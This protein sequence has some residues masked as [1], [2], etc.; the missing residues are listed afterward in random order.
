ML[1]LLASRQPARAA[2]AILAKPSLSASASFLA[3]SSNPVTSKHGAL[4]QPRCTCCAGGRHKDQSH[5][6]TLI[7]ASTPAQLAIQTRGMKVRS[8]VKLFCDG[9]SVVRRKGMLYGGL[10][11]LLRFTVCSILILITLLFPPYLPLL[12]HPH[13]QSSATKTPST[14]RW[15]AMMSAYNAAQQALTQPYC[16]IY[17][18]K[19]SYQSTTHC[20]QWSLFFREEQDHA[21]AASQSGTL[22][23]FQSLQARHWHLIAHHRN[24]S[25]IRKCR[26]S[27]LCASYSSL[28]FVRSIGTN[29]AISRSTNPCRLPSIASFAFMVQSQ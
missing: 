25:A 10:W 13:T 4:Q 5:I 1:R 6:P 18:D 26:C 27:I 2:R 12:V 7:S 21:A 22:A 19:A 11:L 28:R 14:S 15:A 8:S 9:C 24:I 23:P 16:A 17:S 20:P 3:R 29:A